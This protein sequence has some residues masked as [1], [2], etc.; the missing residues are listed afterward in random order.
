MT[1]TQKFSKKLKILREVNNYTQE[2]VARVL[3]ISQN[4]YSLLE[5]GTTKITLDRIEVLATLYSTTPAELVNVSENIY[6]GNSVANEMMHSNVP[7]T[8]SSFEKRM[9]EQTISR[10]EID[11][12]KLYNLINQLATSKT[13]SQ[14]ETNS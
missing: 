1:L 14:T 13:A 7:P 9:Y 6:N 2:Y 3:D 11:I 10:L 5:K 8:L 4:A 12:E